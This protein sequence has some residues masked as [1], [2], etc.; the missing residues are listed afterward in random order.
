MKDKKLKICILGDSRSPQ[1]SSYA[2]GMAKLG[3]KVH[4][5]SPQ[6]AKIKGVKVHPIKTKVH[7]SVNY[8]VSYFKVRKILRQIKPDI[9]HGI[10]VGSLT[11]L[12]VL[13]RFHPFM[14][15]VFGSDVALYGKG[16]KPMFLRKHIVKSNLRKSDTVQVFDNDS[17]NYLGR[18]Y[19]IPRDRF[20]KLYWGIDPGKTSKKKKKKFDVLFLRK[21]EDKYSPYVFIEAMAIVK[22]K[23]PN[24]R[25]M[26]VK[27]KN[28]KEI[29]KLIDKEGLKKNI[30]HVD[31]VDHSKINDIMNSSLMYVDSFHR[32][33][34]G[35]GFGWTI[36]ESMANEL[37]VILADNPGVSE[38]IKSGYDGFIY[39]QGDPKD[40]A[41]CIIKL[42]KDKKL[43]SKIGKNGRKNLINNLNWHKNSLIEE[44]RYFELVRKYKR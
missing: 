38:Y 35:S 34:P 1:E 11:Y 32:K 20:F 16:K 24:V 14:V 2:E 28:H 25:S 40:L 18:K 27:G 42:L 13:S 15:T 19:N 33:I 29:D 44:K 26:I 23:F 4:I 36:M 8:L 22:Q 5:I 31:W 43:R 21:S 9:L 17:V 6:G 30:D 12:G 39:K 3:H 41:E 37:P 7:W 10:F